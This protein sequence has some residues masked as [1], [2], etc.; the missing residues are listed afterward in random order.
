[1]TYNAVKD[2]IR[3]S[4]HTAIYFEDKIISYD[5]MYT[6]VN[7][8]RNELNNRFKPG[9]L[10]AIQM[11]DCP[12]WIY[13]FWGCVKA[14]V[15]PYLYST[16][17]REN[18][19]EDL[20]TRYPV[21]HIFTDDNII[22]F[23][24]QAQ[25]I[26]DNIPFKTDP[27]DLCFYM[28]TS[29]TTGYICRVP[30]CH[31][32]MAFTAINYAKKTI[33]LNAYDITFSAAKLFFAYGF[34]NSNTFPFFVGGSVVLMKEPSTVK[35]VNQY[36]EKYKPSVYFGV[37]SILAGQIRS[38]KQSKKDFS[39]LRIAISAGEALPG[40]ILKDWIEL[41]N[42]PIL[43]G[44][45]TTECLHI[46]ISNRHENFEPNCSGT[47]VPGYRAK[48]TDIS[49]KDTP[50][51]EVGYLS[52]QGG[53]LN[54]SD[55]WWSTG[56]MYIKR[57]S[58][59]YYQGRANDMLKIGGVWVS[60]V[61]VE[62]E[63]LNHPDVSECGVV[64]D[65]S[66]DKLGKLKAFVVLNNINRNNINT[67]ISIKRACMKNLPLNNYPSTIEFIDELPRTATGKLRRHVLRV[68]EAFV[69]NE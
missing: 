50:E 18:E 45:G 68:W 38:L 32:D 55:E 41:F 33:L 15:I 7:R 34:G 22:E 37:P 56:D 67:K 39:F 51:G 36:I 58:R 60:P 62:E 43:D 20:Y 16:M 46:F 9:E 35:S 30:H 4:P 27:K 54:G 2:F 66:Q 28:F 52:I 26:T 49:D 44:I 47:L 63:I 23:D 13:L 10:V 21:S 53:S 42:V 5:E 48:I 19:Y 69:P 31:F 24:Q 6:N 25:D 40:K 14:G 59:F 57:G 29:G 11:S 17:L 61:T 12:E 1:M 8:Y 3:K 65:G 64:Y